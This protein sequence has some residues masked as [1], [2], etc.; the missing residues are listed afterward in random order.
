[1]GLLVT[2]QFHFYIPTV[3]VSQEYYF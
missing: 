3:E 1:M 2:F